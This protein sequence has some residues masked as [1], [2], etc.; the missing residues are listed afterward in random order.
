[1]ME[2]CGGLLRTEDGGMT[3]KQIFDEEAHVYAAALDP[4]NPSTIYINTFDSAAFRSDDRGA[5][6]YRLEGY[7]F[8]WGHRPVVDPHNPGMLYLTTFGGSVF[9]GPAGGVPGAF[10][11]IEEDDFLRW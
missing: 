10:E 7:N 2:H 11:D 4:E 8:K 5:N 6:W 3:W 1:M 9:H